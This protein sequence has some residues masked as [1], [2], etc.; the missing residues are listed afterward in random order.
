MKVGEIWE[1]MS[2]E[3]CDV[4]F[5]DCRKLGGQNVVSFLNKLS[6][7]CKSIH[8]RC[9]SRKDF[10]LYCHMMYG[11]LEEQ[12]VTIITLSELMS[13]VAQN[14]DNYALLDKEEVLDIL[15]SLDFPGLISLLKSKDNLDKEKLLMEAKL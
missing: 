5:L 14:T 3:V 6:G 15:R 9:K 12:K 8:S 13:A 4:V 7:V 2:R 11:L 1:M 10:S